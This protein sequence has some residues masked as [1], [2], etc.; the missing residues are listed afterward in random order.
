[1][2]LI[3]DA[4]EVIYLHETGL[5]QAVLSRCEVHLAGTVAEVEAKY[6]QGPGPTRK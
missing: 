6:Y 2:L 4:N 1:V 3:L 5:W